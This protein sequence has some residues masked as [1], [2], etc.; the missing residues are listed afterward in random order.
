MCKGGFAAA[1]TPAV[2]LRMPA[3]TEDVARANRGRKWDSIAKGYVKNVSCLNEK[4]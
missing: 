1:L 4:K 2:A 3:I